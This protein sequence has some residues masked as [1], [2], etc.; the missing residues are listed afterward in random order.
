MV[1]LKDLDMIIVTTADPLHYLSDG[2]LWQ[3][4][5][6]IDNLVGTFIESLPKE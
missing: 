3:Y 5:G 2:N 4:E 6:A 1:L